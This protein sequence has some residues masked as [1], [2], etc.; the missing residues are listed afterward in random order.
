M[1]SKSLS[2]HFA[3]PNKMKYLNVSRYMKLTEY[4]KARGEIKLT[5]LMMHVK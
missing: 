1:I 5:L 4:I 2:S 3:D